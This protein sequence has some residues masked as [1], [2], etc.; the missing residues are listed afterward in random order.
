MIAHSTDQFRFKDTY[1][2]RRINITLLYGR[3]D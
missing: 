2:S 1:E 3:T